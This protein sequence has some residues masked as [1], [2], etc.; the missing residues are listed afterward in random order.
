MSSVLFDNTS[1]MAIC[2]LERKADVLINFTTISF[3]SIRTRNACLISFLS[4]NKMLSI[5]KNVNK[6]KRF[7]RDFL[8]VALY[9]T[10]RN[11]NFEIVSAVTLFTDQQINSQDLNEFKQITNG[12]SLYFY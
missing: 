9:D 3:K 6:F 2:V 10:R 11:V 8:V 4:I 12:L 5:N 1:E 7:Y